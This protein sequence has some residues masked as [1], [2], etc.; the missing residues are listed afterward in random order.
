MTK[1]TYLQIFK[2]TIFLLSISMSRPGV[3]TIIW[4]PLRITSKASEL[5]TP[6]IAKHDLLL[7]EKYFYRLIFFRESLLFTILLNK[8]TDFLNSSTYCLVKYQFKLFDKN[9]KLGRNPR[10]DSDL[11]KKGNKS[12]KKKQ[13]S[14]KKLKSKKE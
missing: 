2:L 8:I 12:Q 6:P 10:S 1:I 11:C 7:D 13:K 4:T 5:G 14:K 3:A 9:K